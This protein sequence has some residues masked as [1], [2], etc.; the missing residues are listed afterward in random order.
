SSPGYRVII[1]SRQPEEIRGRLPFP[2]E[3][4][5]WKGA[6]SDLP[7]EI[8][9]SCDGIINLVGEGIADKPWT[10]ARRELIQSSRVD[11]VAALARAIQSADRKPSVVIQASAIG[12]Y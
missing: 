9:S 10:Q 3:L 4:I 2:C 5:R 1:T 7:A 12:Y 11:S 8:V 6:D